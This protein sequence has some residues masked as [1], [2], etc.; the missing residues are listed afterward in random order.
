[1]R[2]S[3]LE[4]ISQDYIRTAR[5]E[6]R[7]RERVVLIRHALRNALLPMITLAG[8]QLPTLLGGALVTET[9]FTWPG[10]GRLFLDSLGYRDYPGR[11]GTADVHRAA[12]AARQPAGATCCTPSPIPASGSAEAAHDDD[13]DMP[14]HR[15]GRRELRRSPRA[16]GTRAS[17][18][19]A[20]PPGAARLRHGHRSSRLLSCV[21]PYLLPF[22]DLHIDILHRFAPPFAERMCSAPIRSGA[23]CSR[24]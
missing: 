20:P 1:M 18:L 22:N 15:I 10:M 6:G 19:H 23:T 9:V 11:H 13:A 3:M 17:T 16:G 24:G 4:V 7:C 21:G 2:S 8:L 14:R 5:R 12:G